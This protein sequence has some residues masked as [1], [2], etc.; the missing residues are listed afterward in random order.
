MSDCH[1]FKCAHDVSSHHPCS[2]CMIAIT[3]NCFHLS[4]S[5]GRCRTWT[6]TPQA[7]VLRAWPTPAY[8]R[9]G[10]PWT[11]STTVTSPGTYTLFRTF[12]VRTVQSTN[13]FYFFICIG[14]IFTQVRQR[15]SGLARVRVQGL[16][17]S[18]HP[19]SLVFIIIH[20]YIRTYI[21]AYSNQSLTC[22]ST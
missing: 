8:A 12:I 15:Q 5:L 2:G 10:T 21:C 18:A 3:S 9:C 6:L 11:A 17:V 7:H 13:D 14:L 20:T 19:T 22:R 4:W 16:P 1:H